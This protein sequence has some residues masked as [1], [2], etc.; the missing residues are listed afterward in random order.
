MVNTKNDMFKRLTM[1][2]VYVL[3]T[4]T[5]TEKN[6]EKTGRV[7]IVA[8]VILRVSDGAKIKGLSIK[9]MLQALYSLSKYES[10]VYIHN[11]K[12]DFSFIEDFILT[13]DYFKFTEV[14]EI[15]RWN[16]DGYREIYTGPY[17]YQTLR[18]SMS[19]YS[20]DLTF[21]GINSINLRDSAKLY[22]LKVSQIGESIGIAKLTSDFDYEK[23]RVVGEDLTSLEWTYVFHDVQIIAKM[24]LKEFTLKELRSSKMSLTR[25]GIAYERFR[26]LIP[27]WKQ[28]F[29]QIPVDLFMELK[30]AYA[31]GR[32]LV[33]P[34]HAGK[35]LGHGYSID[36]TSMH[37]SSATLD[38]PIGLPKEVDGLASKE[39]LKEYPLA[40]F[41]IS[42][43][44][45]QLKP[46]HFSTLMPN[47]SV[48]GVGIEGIT[49]EKFLR[50]ENNKRVLTLALPDLKL[51]FENYDIKGL[52]FI[53]T[54]AFK[55]GGPV[56]KE[57]VEKFYQDKLKASEEDDAAMRVIAKLILN[58]FYGKLA[59]SVYKYHK[60]ASVDEDNNVHYEIE[61]LDPKE[62]KGYLPAA[63]FITAYSRVSLFDM[64]YRIGYENVVYMDTD[65]NKF[66]GDAIPEA[67]Q[68]L[69]DQLKLGYW[70]IEYEFEEIKALRPKA[71]V[72]NKY[73]KKG[74][75]EISATFA[76]LSGE[77]INGTY[78]KDENGNDTQY[79]ELDDDGEPINT[80]IKSLDD[81]EYRT[82]KNSLMSKR[83]A[84]GTLLFKGD[85]TV[86]PN[87]TITA[88]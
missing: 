76:G 82:Y 51:L 20:V 36:R 34:M 11:I 71:Y 7:D 27:N 13:N 45:M 19:T 68:E 80:G 18:D 48:I 15:A 85:K 40:I 46:K 10:R 88:A 56:F 12:F 37:P 6:Y 30:R 3:D 49:N 72:V 42:L 69:V 5:T 59:E 77:A 43:D 74:N 8:W 57:A 23:E 81:L 29:P 41:K 39:I 32:T 66:I 87:E 1:H 65:S 58:G 25:S 55:N 24:L 50:L 84:G 70:K 14:P 33:N 78:V 26:K 52:H 4:E 62:T 31:G 79:Y 2:D 83:V 64:A 63:I 54:W 44:K 67:A 16:E 61:A 47:H 53:K 86:R 35:K 38:M 60:Q 9:S 75:L 21:D 73:N 28:L 17:T 22:P